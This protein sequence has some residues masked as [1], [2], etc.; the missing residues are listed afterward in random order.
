MANVTASVTQPVIS[1][2]TTDNPV[3]VSQ[4]GNIISSVT[5]STLSVSVSSTETEVNVSPL[6]AIGNETIRQ[7]LSVVDT[8]GDGSLTYSNVTG[9]FTYTGPSPAE[10]RSHFSAVFTGGDGGFD[11]NASTGVFTVTGPDQNEANARISQAPQQV[12]NHFSNVAPILYSAGTGVISLDTEAVFSNTLA[13]AWFTTQTTDDLTEGSSNLYFTTARARESIS[14]DGT[15]INYSNVTGIIDLVSKDITAGAG[16]SGGG[17]T[18]SDTTLNVGQGFGIQVDADKVRL[19]NLE[20]ANFFT[21]G[22]GIDVTAT[23]NGAQYT[24]GT[25]DVDSTVIRT[26]AAN[27]S[28]TGNLQILTGDLDFGD[29]SSTLS[30]TAQNPPTSG[31]PNAGVIF[32]SGTDNYFYLKP[33]VSA[34]NPYFLSEVTNKFNAAVEVNEANLD[35]NTGNINITSGEL[36]V[37]GIEPVYP[38]TELVR[39]KQ[40]KINYLFMGHNGISASPLNGA[41]ANAAVLT[42]D[43]TRT[44]LGFPK[45]NVGVSPG[46]V[47][48]TANGVNNISSVGELVDTYNDQTI[49]GAK[50]FSQDLT[51]QGNVDVQGNLNYVNVVDLLVDNQSI[52]LN[53][54]NVAQDAY[55]YVDRT[56]AGGANAFLSWNETLDRWEFSPDNGGNTF[57]LPRNTTDLAEGTNLYYTTDRANAA[58]ADYDGDI[59]TTGNITAG[60]ITATTEFF[61]DLDG[62]VSTN[63]YN[64]TGVTLNKGKA[65]YLTG[66]NNGD[67]PHVDLADNTDPAKMPALGI[68]KENI[69]ATSEGQ[70]VTSG[71]M[72][73]SSHG[74]TLGADL[75]INGSGSLVETAPTGE[76]NLIQ[77]IGKVVS[78]NHIIVQGAFRTNATPNL[79]E[80]N[81]FLGSSSGTAIAVTPDSNFDTTGNTFSL[82]NTLTDVNTI[83]PETGQNV[84]VQEPFSSQN[85]LTDVFKVDGDGYAIIGGNDF[86][87]TPEITYTTSPLKPSLS[88]FEFEGSTTIGDANITI[89][90][91]RDGESGI[92]NSVDVLSNHSILFGDVKIFPDDAYVIATDIGTGNV[93]MSQNAIQTTSVTYSNDLQFTPS[94]ID[95]DTGLVVSVY[96]QHQAGNT[97]GNLKIIAGQARRNVVYAYPQRGPANV[98]FNI[99]SYATPADYTVNDLSQYTVA[100]TS[101]TPAN[102]VLKA[103]IGITV[104]ENTDLTN[105]AE[106]D[107]FRSFGINMMWDGE[108]SAPGSDRTQQAI[109][110]KNYT[111][112]GAQGAIGQIGSGA[113]RI[114]FTSAN[115]KS[116]DNPFDVYPR[117]NQELG[118]LS[119]WGSTGTNLT[120]SSYNVPAFLSVHAADDWD[121]HSSTTGVAGN[122]NIYFASTADGVN[123]DMFMSYK[124]GELFLAGGGGTASNQPITFLPAD[125]VTGLRPETAYDGAETVWANINYANTSAST[126]SKFTVTNGA[127]VDAGVVGDMQIELKRLDNSSSLATSVSIL[128]DGALVLGASYYDQIFVSFPLATGSSLNGL[129]GTF[130]APGTI[131]TSA[132]G[133]ESA[134]GNNSYTLNYFFSGSTAVYR[135]NNGAV[136]YSSIGGTSPLAFI[137][138]TGGATVST[139]VSSGVTQK[140]WT[141]NLEEQ[142]D[143]L[144]LQGNAST[145]VEFTDSETVFSNRVRFQN[146]DTTAI[147]ALTG[148]AAGDTVFNT[149]ESTLCFY[150]GSAWQKVDK[151]AL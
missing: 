129:T 70:V 140:A 119:F 29:F 4:D 15:N 49:G 84:S 143:N 18:V 130:S 132:S 25:I 22:D 128:W 90:A 135:L 108:T 31:H 24:G 82:S 46:G 64:N 137:S 95:T 127:S 27:Q 85:T 61:G 136:T 53:Y 113:G 40:N 60:I 5:S 123:S 21:G 37:D 99:A 39:H 6:A 98:D 50:V 116:S 34:V 26:V 63:V 86:A 8:G 1:V 134:L 43:P 83:Q 28:I 150:D 79:D 16:L 69:S 9:V 75:F 105:R 102:T 33:T 65:V 66:G 97:S 146:L 125:N 100:R 54:G 93:T 11:Y 118:R 20:L 148:M 124:E 55:I 94:L 89:T 19:A 104:G 114:F 23:S 48:D 30:G 115:G 78:A 3:T 107:L 42:V 14:S 81:I 77:K 68:V 7:A 87:N 122:T 36:Y 120:P 111:D 151:T 74:H 92:S 147:N 139:V 80:G 103:P 106:N 101:L 12:R 133:N 121:T 32:F 51:V 88:Y 141:F 10:V 45:V 112:N 57:V 149:T 44:T 52:T 145:V 13:N 144:K 71:V 56:G 35:V 58:I 38:T 91:M 109:N 2:T 96:N 62:A 117:T 72:N 59:T 17:T 110:I 76:A 73:Y 41:S 138:Q 67:Q 47:W 131:T 142:S 126:G